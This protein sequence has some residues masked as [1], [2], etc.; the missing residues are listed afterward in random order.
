MHWGRHGMPMGTRGGPAP[1]HRGR[2]EKWCDTK[3]FLQCTLPSHHGNQAEIWVQHRKI[4]AAPWH[5]PTMR[6][7]CSPGSLAKKCRSL[8]IGLLQ[9]PMHRQ[10]Q[11]LGQSVGKMGIAFSHLRGSYVAK[12]FEPAKI[13]AVEWH[14]RDSESLECLCS[15]CTCRRAK[16]R[17]RD[18]NGRN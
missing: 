14:G 15:Q 12:W 7:H 10:L 5:F 9:M 1:S 18:G 13:L 6:L 11:S 16:H 8:Y 17:C 2:S 3:D 4:H